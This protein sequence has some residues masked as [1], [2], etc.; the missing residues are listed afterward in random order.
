MTVAAVIPHWNRRQLLETLLQSLGDQTRAFDELIVV[1][2][3]STDD[4]AELA[5]RAGARV[6]RMGRNLGF[7]AAVNRGIE[8]AGADWV[9]ILNND[10]VLDPDWLRILLAAAGRENAHFATG[11]ILRESDPSMIDGT[12]DAISRGACA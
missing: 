10:V 3:G 5:E 6:L 4:S 12:F 11:K 2:N 8:A 7:A 9:V 1:D